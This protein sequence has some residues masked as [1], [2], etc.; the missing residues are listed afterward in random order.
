MLFRRKARP[1]LSERVRIALW[2]RR[3]FGRSFSYYRHRVLRLEASPH[4]IAAGVAA[5]AFASCTPLVGFHFLLSFIVAWMVGGSMIAAAFG[6]AVGNP[7]TFPF[8][9]LSSFKLGQ[10]ILGREE[11]AVS[12]L[13]LDLSFD[14]LW[15]SFATLWPTLKPML[16]GGTIIGLVIGAIL[17]F[18]TRSAVLVSRSLREAR[19]K[20]RLAAREAEAG[21]ADPLASARDGAPPS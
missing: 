7:L 11:G 6:T 17:Y 9:W 1:T 12:P 13:Q 21:N 20:A 19:L 18:L 5:G 15:N 14:L 3:S 8:I 4:A 10:A 16:L 2:P